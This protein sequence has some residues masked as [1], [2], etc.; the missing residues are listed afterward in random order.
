[1]KLTDLRVDGFGIWSGINVNQLSD[2]LTVFYG[3]NEAGKTTLLQFIRTVLYGFSTERR[4][5]YLPPVNGGKPGGLIGLE[6]PLGRYYVQRHTALID[7]P[8]SLGDVEVTTPDGGVFGGGALGTLLANVDE[9]IFNNVFAVG[10]RELQELNTIDDTAAADLLYKLTSGLDRVSLVDVMRELVASRQRLLAGDDRPSQITSLLAQRAKLRGEIDDL[11]SL[12]R[13]WSRLTDQRLSL[14]AEAVELGHTTHE[15][16]HQVRLLDVTMQVHAAWLK[17]GKLSKEIAGFGP[18]QELPEGAIDKLDVL[19]FKLKDQRKKLADVAEERER[20]KKEIAAIPVHQALCDA[21]P[22]IELYQEQ[23]PWIR[24]LDDQSKRLQ[25]E[26]TN[27]ETELSSQWGDI[28]LPEGVVQQKLPEISKKTVATV[29]PAAKLVRKESL[30][31]KLAS[32]DAEAARSELADLETRLSSTLTDRDEEDLTP[33]IEK[34]SQRVQQ[35]RR[36]LQV[37]ERIDQLT[38]QRTELRIATRELDDAGLL[39]MPKL[40]AVGAAFIFGVVM[41]LMGLAGSVM[42]EMTGALAWS[43]LG[44]MC[45]GGS[46]LAKQVLEKANTNISASTEV[47]L[48]QLEAQVAAAE[49]ERDDLDRR[50]PRGG[51]ALDRR[52]ATAQ[53]DLE[54]LEELVPIEGQRHLVRERLQQSETRLSKHQNA[55]RDARSKWKSSLKAAGLPDVL[56]PEHIR[57]LAR[58][59]SELSTIR[60]RINTLK[61]EIDQ[62]QREL[63][64]I[65]SRIG[66]LF[67]QAEITPVSKDLQQQLKQL[68]TALAEAQGYI[69]R[70]DGLKAQDR[71]YRREHRKLTHRIDD[72]QRRRKSLLV[73]CGCKNDLQ[74][75]ERAAYLEEAARLTRMH[76][77]VASQIAAMVR[78]N[79]NEEQVAAELANTNGTLVERRDD[80]TRRLSEAQARL[81]DVYQQRGEIQHELKTLVEDRRIAYAQ[82][83]LAS[84]ERQLE[85]ALHKWR[86]LAA[87]WTVLEKICRLYEAERQPETLIEASHYLNK[88]T[89]G[90]Y[91][92]LWTPLGDKALRVD[93]KHGHAL[94]LEVLS[95]GTREAIFLSLR[96]ALIAGYARRGAKL[97]IILDDVLVNLDLARMKAAASVLRDFAR[98]GHQLLLFTCHEHIVEAFKKLK[99][100]VRTLPVRGE[101]AE[102]APPLP[103]PVPEPTFIALPIIEKPEP[104]LELAFAEPLPEPAP[105]APTPPRELALWQDEELRLSDEELPIAAE[106][107]DDITV[108]FEPEPEPQPEFDFTLAEAPP[109][110]RPKPLMPPARRAETVAVKPRPEPVAKPQ[111]KAEPSGFEELRYDEPMSEPR[112][113]RFTWESPERWWHDPNEEDAA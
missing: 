109:A 29:M 71:A 108:D 44:V 53:A 6:G 2:Q 85:K 33:A 40:V 22:K 87:T 25:G 106:Y 5:R 94:R 74:L 79:F 70:R 65:G 1:M 93:D 96:L 107:L 23:L 11:G 38:R 110:R 102:V 31:I 49:G 59:S 104:E 4:S 10:L 19:Q 56:A 34:A 36:R 39:P 28:K 113:S 61:Q 99:V 16:E 24:Q 32:R 97:P 41:V 60:Q 43:V 51:G 103:A 45:I 20:V 57:M 95:T 78:P 68:A 81:A 89:Q 111:R 92:R 67:Q 58:R 14:D 66:E 54:A 63:S 48:E 84:V 80:V 15:L 47:Q 90:Q 82:L 76:N 69:A 50:L 37:E 9:A 98:S 21:A 26:L 62:R 72:V 101:V 30:R 77:E 86:V 42:Y 91:V 83:E 46:V 35:L 7:T 27:L 55:A 73:A 100:E 64:L 13:R 3:P 52:L 105:L 18:L 17:R 12:E 8:T 112:A 75:R 88:L